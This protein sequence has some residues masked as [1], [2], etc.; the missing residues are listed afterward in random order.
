MNAVRSPPRSVA[1]AGTA[2]APAG[3]PPGEPPAATTAVAGEL[4]ATARATDERAAARARERWL[5]RLAGP[6][7][8][9]LR[10]AAACT[11]AAGWLLPVQAGALAWA[12]QQVL[13]E[14][15]PPAALWPVLVALGLALG[16]RALLA[17]AAQAL[18]GSVA[19]AARARLRVRLHAA[20]L[21][22]G[23]AWLRGQRRGALAELLAAHGDALENYYAGHVLARWEVAWVPPVLLLA[24]AWVDPV[25]ALILALTAPLIPVFMMLVGWGVQAASRDQL[26]ALARLGGHFADRLRGL[27]LLRLH[28]QG[29]AEREGIGRAAEDL[30]QRSLRVL[31]IAFLSSAVLEFFASVSVAGVALYLGLGFLGEIA[32]PLVWRWSPFGL[33]AGVFCLLLAPEV[34]APL[35]RLAAHYHERAAALAAVGAIEQALGDLPD[36]GAAAAPVGGP[37]EPA[38]DGPVVRAR[39]LCLRHADAAAPVLRGLDLDLA[40][41]ARIGV[42]GPSGAGKSSLLDALSGAVPVDGG[43][44][45]VRARRVGLAVQRPYLFAGS[46]AD[47]LRLGR[48]EADDGAVREAAA[49]AQLSALAARLPQGLDTPVGE[50][51]FGL[52]GGEA[53]RVALARVLLR[54]PD[55]VLLDEPTAFLDPGTEAALLGALA[56]WLAGRSLVMATHSPAALALVERVLWLPEAQWLTPAQAAARLSGTA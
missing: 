37:A 56:P 20:L 18:A 7:R 55:L 53:R 52:S 19:D 3:G 17:Q 36:W 9:R 29:E 1:A 14:G 11:V 8:G 50:R 41:G 39:G 12:V 46:L 35:R 40:R 23:P 15:R 16:S 26:E 22:R 38:S 48:P 43:E 34:H 49:L 44:L 4:A 45:Q 47:N 32:L 24:L 6:Q 51:G 13:V 27:G 21:A 25:V 31:R 5:G 10:A 54:D 33:G 30:R 28:G 42:A 2:A